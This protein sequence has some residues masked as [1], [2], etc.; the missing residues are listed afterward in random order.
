MLTVLAAAAILLLAGT[1]VVLSPKSAQAAWSD[2]NT[3]LAALVAARY[4]AL[5]D[6]IERRARRARI[7]I[8][9]EEEG[10]LAP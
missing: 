10:R 4:A 5:A 8:L 3:A 9:A 2:M 1:A 6:G 7:A